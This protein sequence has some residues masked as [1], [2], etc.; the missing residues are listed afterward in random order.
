[1]QVVDDGDDDNGD[2]RDG[3]RNGN[4]N[5]NGNS[6]DAAAAAIGDTVDEDNCGALGMAIGQRQL[7]NGNGTTTM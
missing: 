6:D 4:G 1:M 5:G 2:G 3:D 7:D